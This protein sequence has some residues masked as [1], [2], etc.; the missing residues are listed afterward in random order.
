MKEGTNK[1]LE[2]HW[3]T[4]VSYLDNILLELEADDMLLL[5][6]FGIFGKLNLFIVLWCTCSK[7]SLSLKPS[8][9]VSLVHLLRKEGRNISLLSFRDLLRDDFFLNAAGELFSLTLLSLVLLLL[10]RSSFIL[11]GVELWLEP[12]L[13]FVNDCSDWSREDCWTINKGAPTSTLSLAE[14]VC[15]TLWVAE[16][17]KGVVEWVVGIAECFWD[18]LPWYLSSDSMTKLSMMSSLLVLFSLFDSSPVKVL[19]YN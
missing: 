1:I 5:L 12:E 10:F 2:T 16:C 17:S 11:S 18:V 15:C 6:I 3:V 9:Q 19:D 4:K 13:E 8:S 14:L 7:T